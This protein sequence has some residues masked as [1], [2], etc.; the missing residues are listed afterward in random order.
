MPSDLLISTASIGNE[1]SPSMP[2][3]VWLRHCGLPVFRADC[4]VDCQ[5]DSMLRNPIFK[6]FASLKLAVF[7]ILLLA[8]VLATA[9][10]L[11]SLFGMRA[12]HV[13]VYGTWWF[14]GVLLLLGTNVFCAAL[15]V[16]RGRDGR[17]GSSSTHAGFLTLLF[18]A[19]LTQRFGVDGN[20][21]VM[22]GE[23]RTRWS[24]PTY[25]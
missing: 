8:S 17:L 1:A 2:I 25:A 19:L 6:F 16:I 24:S 21:P 13:M 22:E 5:A 4:R 12:V 18:G 3:T 11:E 14:L 7:S 23:E 10:V 15:S 20:L 9:T